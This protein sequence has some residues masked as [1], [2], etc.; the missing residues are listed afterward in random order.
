M[1]WDLGS[2]RHIPC[3]NRIYR[4]HTEPPVAVAWLSLS[5]C[6]LWMSWNDIYQWNWSQGVSSK[7]Q[8]HSVQCTVAVCHL[9]VCVLCLSWRPCVYDKSF[10]WVLV[11][12]T[13]VNCYCSQGISAG[14]VH[15]HLTS[16][17]SCS[18][19]LR[20]LYQLW[21]PECARL[22]PDVLATYMSYT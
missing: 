9:L 17:C 14:W 13:Y 4:E 18:C 5:S 10:H 21:S 11:S 8:L 7:V 20:V 6:P 16:M 22:E 1:L 12:M 2:F 3:S 15:S 19:C